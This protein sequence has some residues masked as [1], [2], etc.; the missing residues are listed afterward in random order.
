MDG[1]EVIIFTWGK[2][3]KRKDV[4]DD[5]VFET[6]EEEH[7]HFGYGGDDGFRG[8]DL[9]AEH[10]KIARWGDD[11]GWCVSSRVCQELGRR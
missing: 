10:G 2:K 3:G 6:R 8:P 9:V 7:G 5:L 11:A 4:R 1:C